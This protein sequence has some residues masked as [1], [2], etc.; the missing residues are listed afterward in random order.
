MTASADGDFEF[1]LVRRFYGIRNVRDAAAARDH[2]RPLVDE[3]VV[4]PPGLL[5]GPIGRLQKLP[6]KR[7]G[8]L[9]GCAG[10]DDA[11]F[12]ASSFFGEAHARR[13]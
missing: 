2:R 13:R 6:R 3:A 9:G 12:M 1:L 5:V 4:D 7:L 11:D 10:K 8:K